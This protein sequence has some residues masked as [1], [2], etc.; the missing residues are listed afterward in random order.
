MEFLQAPDFSLA[1]SQPL[2]PFGRGTRHMKESFFRFLS[3]SPSVILPLNK[4]KPTFTWRVENPGEVDRWGWHHSFF[5]SFIHSADT[6]ARRARAV[7]L[8]S[9]V[10][11][12]MDE[13]SG[14]L[15]P[16]PAGEA[17]LEKASPPQRVCGERLGRGGWLARELRREGPADSHG[18]PRPLGTLP[19]AREGEVP[20]RSRPLWSQGPFLEPWAGEGV[21]RKTSTTCG[22]CPRFS[23]SLAGGAGECLRGLPPS[24]AML[25]CLRVALLPVES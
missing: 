4:I 7:C 24:R 8:R 14:F 15:T 22:R 16:R 17:W 10:V 13:V 23:W 1:S 21:G 19:A 6:G 3:L 5:C 9:A 20:A 12:G 2:R 18:F 25:M 11:S